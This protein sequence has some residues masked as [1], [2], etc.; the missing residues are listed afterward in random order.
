MFFTYFILA[1]ALACFHKYILAGILSIFAVGHISLLYVKTD[2]A[3]SPFII[4]CYATLFFLCC[5]YLLYLYNKLL[6]GELDN[7]DRDS[8]RQ[9]EQLTTLINTDKGLKERNSQLERSL[10]EIVKIY[11]Y[12]KKLGSTM[13]FSEA[14]EALETTLKSLTPFNNGKLILIENNDISKVYGLPSVPMP[15]VEA[16]TAHL[17][18]YEKRLTLKLLKN[19]QILLYEKD[20]LSPLGSLPPNIETL[21]AL[22]LVVENQLV[23]IITLENIPLINIDKIHF[24]TLQFA[25]EVK[26]TQ[27]YEKVKELSTIDSLTQLYLRRH[28]MD[29]FTNELDRGYRQN[30]PL[31]F[32]MIDI[33]YFKRYNDEYGHLVGD[34]ILKKVAGILKEKSR[35]IDLLCRYGGDEFAL[36]LPRTVATDAHIVAERLRRAVN[37]YLFQIAKEQFQISVSIGISSCGPKDIQLDGISETLIDLADKALYQAKSK[38]RNRVVLSR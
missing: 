36:A 3:I 15:I 10:N 13:N 1:V 8:E 9:E 26:K 2:F 17:R 22:P 37:E 6:G 4:I 25:M 14:I 19:V 34:L 12:V 23:G 21:I 7:I 29:L 38:G 31:S 20:K 32:L 33:D 30:Q 24:I 27:L 5:I 28:F 35:E 16:G 18:E 11:E